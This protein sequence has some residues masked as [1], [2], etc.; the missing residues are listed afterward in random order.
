MAC[1]A[2]HDDIRITRRGQR[3][4]LVVSWVAA[5]PHEFG[6]LDPFTGDNHDVKNQLPSL[7]RNKPIELWTKDDL[8][9]LILDALRQDKTVGLAH[10]AEECPLGNA[11]CPENRG[12]ES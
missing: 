5:F 8:T 2:A 10:R 1:V 9:V 12:D 3:Q 11:I 6:R 7:N 4:V